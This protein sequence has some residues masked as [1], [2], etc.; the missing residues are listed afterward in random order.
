MG[1]YHYEYYPYRHT[2][3]TDLWQ[4]MACAKEP[5]NHSDRFLL[6][7]TTSVLK[8]HHR[9]QFGSFHSRPNAR[10]FIESCHSTTKALSINVQR[11]RAYSEIHLPIYLAIVLRCDLLPLLLKLHHLSPI[12][13]VRVIP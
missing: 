10:T 8:L 6:R 5:S 13:I 2:H 12:R 9:R 11:I 4:W 7:S 3:I 1:R